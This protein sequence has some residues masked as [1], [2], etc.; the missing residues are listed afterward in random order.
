MSEKKGNGKAQSVGSAFTMDQGYMAKA[1]GSVLRPPQA[2]GV[3]R[4]TAQTPAANTARPAP[5]KKS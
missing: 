3:V 1:A 5:T 4:N 2:S